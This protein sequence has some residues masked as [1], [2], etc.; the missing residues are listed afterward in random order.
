M[1]NE[2][3]LAVE[4]KKRMDNASHE[5]K[6]IRIYNE[7]LNYIRGNL[8][9]EDIFVNHLRHLYS[10]TCESQT[11]EQTLKN[12]MAAMALLKGGK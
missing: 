11:P 7:Y 5:S 12:T 8:L 9:D 3:G 6:V 1:K 4:A 2:R 10:Y